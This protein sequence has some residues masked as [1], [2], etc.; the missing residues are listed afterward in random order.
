MCAQVHPILNPQTTGAQWW[1]GGQTKPF[2]VLEAALTHMYTTHQH[3]HP[4]NH[5]A[6]FTQRWVLRH[7]SVTPLPLFL[8]YFQ[9]SAKAA[10][11]MQ[12]GISGEKVR[13]C[14][15]HVVDTPLPNCKC[16][17]W[18][19]W[20]VWWRV[21]NRLRLVLVFMASMFGR[22]FSFH[23]WQWLC[24]STFLSSPSPIVTPL[25]TSPWSL[26]IFQ[27]WGGC[28]RSQGVFVFLGVAASCENCR[29]TPHVLKTPENTNRQMLNTLL[30]I[31]LW[32]FTFYPASTF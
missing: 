2:K 29:E 32:L 20:S 1:E 21:T 25:H 23:F 3:T 7:N 4:S 27:M 12:A 30:W 22:A 19:M 11:W 8:W 26:P 14:Y 16:L 24:L 5:S 18:P 13:V 28:G 9:L 15:S 17:R 10:T 6:E 31:C